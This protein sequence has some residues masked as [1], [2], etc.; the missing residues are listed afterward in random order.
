MM[1]SQIPVAMISDEERTSGDQKD[2]VE[3]S[4]Q[5]SHCIG[6]ISVIQSILMQETRTVATRTS[7][8]S[9]R[10]HWHLRKML[11]LMRQRQSLFPRAAAAAAAGAS[12]STVNYDEWM[13]SPSGVFSNHSNTTALH[14]GLQ[15]SPPLHCATYGCS[16]SSGRSWYWFLV[17]AKICT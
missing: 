14:S 17:V 5:S 8:S 1:T 2:P 16:N 9:S 13:E 3:P 15:A 11:R 10:H 7:S 12:T 4:F 6:M